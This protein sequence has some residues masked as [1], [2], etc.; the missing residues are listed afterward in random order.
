VAG[1]FDALDVADLHDGARI[2]AL[3]EIARR[4]RRGRAAPSRPRMR[5][6][7]AAAAIVISCGSASAAVWWWR[8]PSRAGTASAAPSAVLQVAMPAR[9]PVTTTP[10]TE[11]QTLLAPAPAPALA[12]ALAIAPRPRL[13]HPAGPAP[14]RGDAAVSA[15]SLLR[16]ATDARRSGAR[17][18]A[19]ELYRRLER[20]FRGSPE[21]VLAAVPL[22]RLLLETGYPRAALAALDGYLGAARGGTL[23]PEALYGRARALAELGDRAEERKTWQ[24]LCADF[25]GSVYAPLG[26]RRLVE[27]E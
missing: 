8:S 2:R 11:L 17:D 25:P 9:A 13:G 3:S 22:G 1:A 14:A 23:I 5:A 4:A 15:A 6:V 16:Q 20:D 21:A 24:R 10:S 19:V 12:P 7:A 18:R 27:L 26:R